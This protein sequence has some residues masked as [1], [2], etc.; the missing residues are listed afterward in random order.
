MVGV[1][2]V[3]EGASGTGVFPSKR[4]ELASRACGAEDEDLTVEFLLV[5]RRKISPPAVRKCIAFSAAFHADQCGTHLPHVSSL[6]VWPNF[7]DV[8]A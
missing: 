8:A 6:P 3:S 5:S 1:Q 2:H 7:V 4:T